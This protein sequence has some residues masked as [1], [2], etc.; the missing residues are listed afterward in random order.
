MNFLAHIYLSGESDEIKVGNFIGDYVKGRNYEKYPDLVKRGILLHRKIDSFTDK[1]PVVSISKTH[2]QPRFHK[3]A[4]VIVDIFYDHFLASEWK[5]F[6]KHPLP[7]YVI[8]MYETLVANYF[9]LPNEIKAFLPFFIINNWLEAYTTTQGISGVLRRMVRRTSLPN[10][11]TFAMAE[12]KKNYKLFRDE[13]Y[14]YFPQLIAY[15]EE[16]HNIA[17][18]DFHEP[19]FVT[20]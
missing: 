16:R 1:H 11:T 17:V 12:L 20:R 13:F 6:S 5:N 19:N 15:V 4:G 14:E 8:H 7:E 2:L 3:Y 18:M 10:E 9:L